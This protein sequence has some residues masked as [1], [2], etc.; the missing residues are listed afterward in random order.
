MPN[1]KDRNNTNN[2]QNLINPT[3]NR[4]RDNTSS[5]S[6]AILEKVAENLNQVN[7]GL[8][9]TVKA[10]KDGFKQMSS[11]DKKQNKE[12][13]T[14]I[15]KLTSTIAEN[16]KSNNDKNKKANSNSSNKNN[17]SVEQRRQARQDRLISKQDKAYADFTNALTKLK[18]EIDSITDNTSE[19]SKRLISN[20]EDLNKFF[21]EYKNSI[22]KVTGN[23]NE[24]S[25]GADKFEKALR[26]INVSYGSS[27]NELTKNIADFKN[28]IQMARNELDKNDRKKVEQAKKDILENE[29][30]IKNAEK[31]LAL[32]IARVKADENSAKLNKT[33]DDLRYNSELRKAKFEKESAKHSQDLFNTLAVKTKD[34][35]G[36][37]E[38]DYY[39][40]KNVEISK[41]IQSLSE[42]SAKLEESYINTGD[43]G[44][45][46]EEIQGTLID[47]EEALTSGNKEDYK[48]KEAILKSLEQS[49]ESIISKGGDASDVDLLVAKQNAENA[50]KAALNV[51]VQ[52][53]LASKY[54]SQYTDLISN[55]KNT[56]DSLEKERDLIEDKN[57]EDYKVI[58]QQINETQNKL[59]GAL[60]KGA[61]IAEMGNQL[62]TGGI[63][64]RSETMLDSLQPDREAIEKTK[65]VNFKELD[66]I[67]NRLAEVDNKLNSND[68]SKDDKKDLSNNKKELEDRKALIEK[69]NDAIEKIEDEILSM[70]NNIQKGDLKA[71]AKNMQ[72]ITKMKKV[73]DDFEDGEKSLLEKA[74][75]AFEEMKNNLK[76]QGPISKLISK[77][78]KFVA[79]EVIDYG[80]KSFTE[81]LSKLDQS[82]KNQ[83]MNIAKQNMFTR[84][85]IQRMM[86]DIGKELVRQGI[87][88]IDTT[89]VM[90]MAETLAN[91]GVTDEKVLKDMS[92]AMSKAAAVNPELKAEFG[93]VNALRHYQKIYDEAVKLG[94]N[95]A[96]ALEKELDATGSALRGVKQAN[97]NGY[98]FANGNL[99]ELN[100]AMREFWDR[101]PNMTEENRND[102][103]KGTYALAGVVGKN[104]DEFTSWY[105]NMLEK[106]KKS[107]SGEFIDVI[108][109]TTDGKEMIDAYNRHDMG[110]YLSDAY[111]KLLSYDYDKTTGKVTNWDQSYELLM[112]HLGINTD[113]LN[114]I[115]NNKDY[116]D[117]DGNFD[118]NKFK[119]A[120][121]KAYEAAG[122]ND[123]EEKKKENL[124]EGMMQTVEETVESKAIN[125]LTTTFTTIAGTDIPHAIEET[126]KASN[127]AADML[128]GVIHDG[129]DMLVGAI[130]GSSLLGKGGG[131]GGIG[132]LLKM[133]PSVNGE[134][135]LWSKGAL[136]KAGVVGAGV[137]AFGVG[138]DIGKKIDKWLG[139]SEWAGKIDKETLEEYKKDEEMRERSRKTQEEVKGATDDLTKAINANTEKLGEKATEI[140]NDETFKSK[141][142]EYGGYARDALNKDGSINKDY[143]TN[144]NGSG[145]KGAKTALKIS[146]Q[147]IAGLAVNSKDR[148]N[149]WKDYGIDTFK[150]LGFTDEQ[151][152]EQKKYYD[153]ALKRYDEMKKEY[154]D[155]INKYGGTLY[156]AW[157]RFNTL[158]SQYK[159]SNEA[160]N[161]ALYQAAG[162]ANGDNEELYKY[163]DPNYTPI[164]G[165]DF[166]IEGNKLILLPNAHPMENSDGGMKEFFEYDIR[167]MGKYATGLDYVPY[168]N[169]PALLHKGEKVQT[170]AEAKNSLILED[171]NKNLDTLNYN[172]GTITD[173]EYEVVNSFDDEQIISSIQTQTKDMNELISSVLAILDIIANNTHNNS[174]NNTN[175]KP[176]YIEKAITNRS[177]RLGD[178]KNPTMY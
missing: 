140:G 167:H 30:N 16:T 135:G 178:Y 98:A 155:F 74:G 4:N 88:G 146:A 99:A 69:Q 120:Y 86:G 10:I 145:E 143:S 57:S 19:E 37:D 163:H 122:N 111:S 142:E 64:T 7:S 175:S 91:N 21:T 160:W 107:L 110:T 147:Q 28:K 176:S 166:K 125:T 81:S 93:D 60:S 25:L 58:A 47:L 36:N 80:A 40:D 138:W 66:E 15:G 85:D 97:K 165:K 119:E 52:Q 171:I 43:K 124:E 67:N 101:M 151:I 137:A 114:K 71:A 8:N 152:S 148:S 130:S 34:S 132:N 70:V 77:G 75:S 116:A 128:K 118:I 104:G 144:A 46:Y 22:D 106:S 154:D 159:N 177:T 41:N 96:E 55:L 129:I 49:R 24:I 42:H 45:L 90:D 157:Q 164:E 23:L 123:Y 14:A 18:E 102:M 26:N 117:K 173:G 112:E 174:V 68:L 50:E 150:N 172:R 2:G 83:G 63:K 136:G 33:I 84:K 127:A 35:E 59:S 95:G 6:D 121:K 100:S 65:A 170:A 5:T 9:D 48:I 103:R 139:I 27:I 115:R 1:N 94:K 79:G 105:Q 32:Q 92:I 169:F 72:N 39:N 149:F 20:Y 109:G 56:L 38:I 76:P 153:D 11:T 168:D 133:G 62:A 156:E 158:K 78:L 82:Y 29:R 161:M 53:E 12:L 141:M 126:I 51:K 131:S 162:D 87:T 13:N 113:D 134:G 89:D 17:D 44:P 61:G 73:V 31:L 108:Q 54:I 3:P